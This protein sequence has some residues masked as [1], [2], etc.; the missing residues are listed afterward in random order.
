MGDRGWSG[1]EDLGRWSMSLEVRSFGDGC[2]PNV[3][4]IFLNVNVGDEGSR[5]IRDVARCSRSGKRK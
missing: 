4:D 1:G 2:A 3:V 5:S